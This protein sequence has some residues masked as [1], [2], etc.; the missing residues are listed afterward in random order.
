MESV[1]NSLRG[2][3]KPHQRYLIVSQASEGKKQLLTVVDEEGREQTSLTTRYINR[4]P[5]RFLVVTRKDELEPKV[6]YLTSGSGEL[7]VWNAQTGKVSKLTEANNYWKVGGVWNGILFASR[8]NQSALL[9]LETGEEFKLPPL[10]GLIWSFGGG[11]LMTLEMVP[12]ISSN[13]FLY[14]VEDLLAGDNS[15][16]VRIPYH[17]YT[18]TPPFPLVSFQHTYFLADIGRV[19]NAETLESRNVKDFGHAWSLQGK[20]KAYVLVSRNGYKDEKKLE[21]YQVDT[22]VVTPLPTG[23]SA[24]LG[25]SDSFYVI[26][27][28]QVLYY[29]PVGKRE[30]LVFKV[31]PK[32]YH[33]EYLGRDRKRDRVYY[34][35]LRRIF[36]ETLP[37]DLVGL[38]F[39]AV[40]T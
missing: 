10:R 34:W 39:E 22:Q 26:R 13:T 29:D 4:L 5:G 7:K 33:V 3:L 30:E 31:P 35:Y 21:A 36:R 18:F 40:F 25:P 38:V 23:T 6:A 27:G 16:P 1:L 20:E 12:M 28:Q 2:R 14:R 8:R 37:S 15:H 32:T 9:S 24:F 19:L 17:E 11:Y